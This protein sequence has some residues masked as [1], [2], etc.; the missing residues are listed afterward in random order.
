[1]RLVTQ[2][3]EANDTD[4]SPSSVGEVVYQALVGPSVRQL[5]VV[6]E[7]GGTCAWHGGHKA[8]TAIEMVGEVEHLAILVNYHLE[9]EKDIL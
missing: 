2:H 7:D 4:V 3:C 8:N 6:D 5:G 1:M 9:W